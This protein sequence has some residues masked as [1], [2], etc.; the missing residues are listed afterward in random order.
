MCGVRPRPVG[1]EAT[2][3]GVAQQRLSGW[4]CLVPAGPGAA[5]LRVGLILKISSRTVLR[6]LKH[7]DNYND[8]YGQITER[9][10]ALRPQG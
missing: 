7:E 9:L 3:P 4:E 10:G 1:S 2:C 8:S 6:R 5:A